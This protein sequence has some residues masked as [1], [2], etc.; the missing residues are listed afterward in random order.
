MST[1][2]VIFVEKPNGKYDG[3][4]VN[5]DGYIRSATVNR[6][7]RVISWIEGLG[8]HLNHYWDDYDDILELCK[9]RNVRSIDGLDVEEYNDTSRH[10]KNISKDDMEELRHN[11]CYSYLYAFSE[12]RGEKCWVAGRGHYDGM[13]FLDLFFDDPDEYENTEEWWNCYG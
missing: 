6:F 9:G 12:E 4:E 3:V 8:W 1:N 7:G 10:L 5:F 13:F 2:A 11:Y